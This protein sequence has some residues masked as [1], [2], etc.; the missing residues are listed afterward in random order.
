MCIRDSNILVE[1]KGVN[2]PFKRENVSQV[3]RHVKDYAESHSIYGA[4]VCKQCKG[5][6][7]INPYS[8]SNINDRVTKEYY[9][10]E[11][12]DDIK[13]DNVCAI[14]TFTLLNYYSKWRQDNKKIN[15]KKIILESNYIEPNFKEIIKL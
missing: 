7:I 12:I 6:L 4:D 1:I 8:T 5:V 13:Y 10:K 14:D 11:V 15:M 3:T 9:S 2:H